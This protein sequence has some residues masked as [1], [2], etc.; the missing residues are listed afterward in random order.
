MKR[1]LR[2]AFVAPSLI[3][4]AC[5]SAAGPAGTGVSPS[6][7]PEMDPGAMMGEGAA[8]AHGQPLTATAGPG[9][10]VADVQF[11]QH[12]IAHHALAVAMAAMAP[13]HGAGPRLLQLAEKIGISQR[14]EIAMMKRWLADRGQAVPDEHALH[15]MQMPGM[16]TPAQLAQL[17]DARGSEF[18]RLFLTFMIRHHE[19]AVQMVDAL[20]DSPAAAQDPDLF[21]FV[22]DVAADQ[23]SEIDQMLYLLSTLDANP[24]SESR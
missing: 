23:L 20:F 11:M 24:G 5:A 1:T 16:L 18:D 9:H 8:H 13:S 3:A 15:A 22:T 2:L 19:G 4:A 7:M 6:S 12:M 14:D 21:R 17:G 10:T